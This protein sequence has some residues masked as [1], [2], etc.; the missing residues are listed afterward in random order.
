MLALDTAV[1]KLLQDCGV[2]HDVCSTAVSEKSNVVK[3]TVAV[4]EMPMVEAYASEIVRQ[5]NE[6]KDSLLWTLF[7]T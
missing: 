7:G 5:K 6:V 4:P 1:Y 2:T 3:H